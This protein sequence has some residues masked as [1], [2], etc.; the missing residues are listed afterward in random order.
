MSAT[1][2]KNNTNY[3]DN[4]TVVF[5]DK[6]GIKKEVKYA[7]LDEDQKNQIPPPPPSPPGKIKVLQTQLQKFKNKT[8]YAVWVDGIVIENEKLNSYS[9][10]DFVFVTESFVHKNARS[11]R[12]PQEKQVHLYSE[13][14][15]KK[16]FLNNEDYAPNQT[17]Y[18]DGT[19][20]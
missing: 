14:G 15:F 19:K 20:K 1:A 12:F 7:D 5:K 9:P 8:N 13:K 17:I 6:D 3:Y 2:A 10:N 4:T 11:K 16:A 18:L